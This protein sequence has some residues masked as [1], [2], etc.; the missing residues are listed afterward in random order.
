[1]WSENGEIE[2]ALETPIWNRIQ[3]LHTCT[4]LQDAW[5]FISMIWHIAVII[6][7][8]YDKMCGKTDGT[9]SYYI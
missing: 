4:S 8:K 7:M 3:Y 5:R 1:M 6:L 2:A 9:F